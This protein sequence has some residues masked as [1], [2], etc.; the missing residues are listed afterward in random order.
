MPLPH[1]ISAT[2]ALLGEIT[3]WGKKMPRWGNGA[4]HA[5]QQN[6]SKTENV[7]GQSCVT[8]GNLPS[9]NDRMMTQALNIKP[10]LLSLNIASVHPREWSYLSPPQTPPR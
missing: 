7:K 6:G 9:L 10:S 5:K 3:F 2:L 4:K 8:E 1:R